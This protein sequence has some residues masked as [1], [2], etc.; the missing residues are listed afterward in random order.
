LTWVDRLSD[1]YVEAVQECEKDGYMS[2]EP[3]EGDLDHLRLVFRG[4][5]E[6]AYENGI[7][8]FEIF[9]QGYPW[10]VPIVYCHTPIWHPNIIKYPAE[11]PA[12]SIPLRGSSGLQPNICHSLL[13]PRYKG[14]SGGW[15]GPGSSI[16]ELITSLKSLL[17]IPYGWEIPPD[18]PGLNHEAA[19]QW[20]SG[21][22]DFLKK[23][24]EWTRK[25]AT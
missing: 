12:P 25:Y 7:F 9:L 22:K 11:Y 19:Q 2:I 16:L 4:M 14:K 13:D 10:E 17:S 5:P 18:D 1:D 24:K 20:K 15:M 23:A 6:T 3:W 8:I 21:R